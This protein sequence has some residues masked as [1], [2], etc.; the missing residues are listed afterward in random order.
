MEVY[1]LPVRRS[2]RKVEAAAPLDPGAQI[3]EFIAG[4][5]VLAHD[6]NEADKLGVA[7]SVGLK[8]AQ[9]ARIFR[10]TPAAAQKALERANS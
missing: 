6:A 1:E 5:L 8:A 7:K 10:K 4:V 2:V 9:V 3:L